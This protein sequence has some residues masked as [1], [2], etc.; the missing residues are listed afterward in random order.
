MKNNALKSS[1]YS[2]ALTVD[3]RT[4]HLPV[5]FRKHPTSQ[6]MVIRYQPLQ[7]LIAV[8]LPRY[9]SIR[10]GLHFIEEKR[11]WIEE[12]VRE[13]SARVP[14][15]DG[16]IL[17]VCGTALAIR[18]TGGRGVV[19]IDGG[20]LLVPGDAAFVS[21]RVREWLKKTARHEMLR[22]AC[23]RAPLIGRAIGKVTLRDTHSRWGSCSSDGSLSFSWRLVLAPPEV[24]EYVV[25]HEVAHLLHHNHST[26]FWEAVEKLCPEHRKARKWLKTHGA[27]LWAYG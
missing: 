26:A 1:P 14:F 23:A 11:N 18:H 4:E 8:T 20:S 15:A 16:Q 2:V 24:L 13:R 25:C 22:I 27:T 3:S 6:H 7:H 17:S 21:R 19:R 10:Q 12:Q 5:I 9:V